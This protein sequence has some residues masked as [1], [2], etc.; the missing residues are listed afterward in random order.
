MAESPPDPAGVPEQWRAI[1]AAVVTAVGGGGALAVVFRF[2]TRVVPSGDRRLDAERDQEKHELEE[3]E[4]RRKENARLRAELHEMT[5]NWTTAERLRAEQ[6]L[7]LMQR[8]TMIDLIR[9]NAALRTGM[10]RAL[11]AEW[12]EEMGAGAGQPTLIDNREPR[13]DDGGG[14]PE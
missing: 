2:L 14:G 4:A 5:V 6:A 1:L 8:N 12:D 9:T 3:V 11:L 7:L 10:P 13:E